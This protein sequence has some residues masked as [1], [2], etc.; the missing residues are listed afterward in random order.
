LVNRKV[1]RY[2][3]AEEYDDCKARYAKANKEVHFG[4][5]FSLATQKH[6]DLPEGHELRRVK[7]RIV[8]GG[9]DVQD[10]NGNVIS[11]DELATAPAAMEDAKLCDAWA[12]QK[13]MVCQQSDAEQA[14]TQVPAESQTGDTPP[15]FIELPHELWPKH[16]HGKYRRPV[17]L[18]EMNLYGHP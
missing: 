18:M 6:D 3:T 5:A 1:W 9:N 11:F 8:F 15:T 2:E 7:G 13:G 14:Y 17:V 10:G 12:M 4:R 16:W